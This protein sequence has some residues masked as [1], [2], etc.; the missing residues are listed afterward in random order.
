MGAQQFSSQLSNRG[1]RARILD[2]NWMGY[3][4]PG[5]PVSA[6]LGAQAMETKLAIEF[7]VKDPAQ[8]SLVA[9]HVGR[10]Q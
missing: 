9:V 4:E 6:D 5:D 7:G 2:T 10:L 3:R 1:V 8:G